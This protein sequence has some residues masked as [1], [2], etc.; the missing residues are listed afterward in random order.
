MIIPHEQL[1]EET[2]SNLIEAFISREGTDYG[3]RE[4]AMETKTQQVRHQLDSGKAVILYDADTSEFTIVFKDEL[5]PDFL[6]QE[7]Q[8]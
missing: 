8:D 5:S 7:R 3:E 6:K 4:V 2:L 1:N